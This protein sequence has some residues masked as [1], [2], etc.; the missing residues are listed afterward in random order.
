MADIDPQALEPVVIERDH[1]ICKDC[2]ASLVERLEGW[3]L[4]GLAEVADDHYDD[5]LGGHPDD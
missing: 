4:A 2:R 3:T 1:L 5:C